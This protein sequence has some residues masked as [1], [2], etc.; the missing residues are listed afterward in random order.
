[1]TSMASQMAGFDPNGVGRKG[2]LF[3]LPFTPDTANIVIIPIP[4]EV[5]VSYQAGTSRGPR[6]IL[7]AS[8]QLDLYQ[9]DIPEAW[10]AGIGMA[11]I[12]E[13]WL[14]S[15]ESLRQKTESYLQW[16]E[17][18]QYGFRKHELQ[19]IANEVNETMNSLNK[20]VYEQSKF[21]LER[22]QF[23]VIVG[24]EHSVPLGLL[25]AL[26]E[27]FDDFGI[28]QID[29]HADLRNAYE[30]FTYSHASIMYNTL[31]TTDINTIVQVGIRDICEEEVNY[32]LN[33]NDIHI[34]YDQV[35]KES[36]LKGESW[37]ALCDR[38]ISHLPQNVYISFD[39]DG[40][41]PKLC[42]NTGT[43]VPGGLSY[44][45]ADLLV[46]KLVESGRKIIGFDLCEVAPGEQEEW[47]GNVGA[48]ILYR[49]CNLM[50]VSQNI[51]H[52]RNTTP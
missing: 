3:G 23:P 49:L 18:G 42:P 39:I 41:D 15:N 45:Q 17:E 8:S 32:A 10:K 36:M 4:W 22:E 30:G 16:L 37:D 12:P 43:P 31:Q 33:Y 6:A 35:N 46:K 47:N 21:Y 24:G 29:A 48:R 26:N 20:W 19:N 1:M 28:L 38:F 25:Q 7:E 13:E 51:L 14:A 9:V 40:L 44:E 5:T 52:F 11:A 2:K 27:K 34:Y 50:A